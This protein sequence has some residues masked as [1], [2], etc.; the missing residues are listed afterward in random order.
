MMKFFGKKNI[1]KETPSQ[2]FDK[3]QDM[4]MNK[5]NESFLLKNQSPSEFPEQAIRKN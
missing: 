3:I 4:T 1:F 2:V 5:I